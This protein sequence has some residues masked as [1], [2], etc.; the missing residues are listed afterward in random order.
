MV[1]L[2]GSYNESLS[3]DSPK[4]VISIPWAV[5][6]S[7]V[8]LLSLDKFPISIVNFMYYFICIFDVDFIKSCS[9]LLLFWSALIAIKYII[10]KGTRVGFK[11]LLKCY[12]FAASR[13]IYFLLK[14]NSRNAF[15][16]IL[17]NCILFKHLFTKTKIQ[18][19][20]QNIW[21]QAVGAAYFSWFY[22][23]C[24]DFYNISIS[25]YLKLFK[26]VDIKAISINYNTSQYEPGL[27][28]SFI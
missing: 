4:K 1:I 9:M 8:G 12:D 14:G 11:I 19:L 7:M 2:K 10:C 17:F 27:P 26:E 5:V 22:Y 15:S 18:S 13:M 28:N 6:C 3:F 23:L 24:K 25:L 20:K 21:L 16:I